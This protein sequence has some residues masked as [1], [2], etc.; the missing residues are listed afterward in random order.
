MI[1]WLLRHI[2]RIGLRWFYR[3]IEVVGAE[4]LPGDGPVLLV[5]NHNNALIDALLVVATMP[6]RVRL[7]AKATLLDHVVTRAAVRAVGIIPLRRASDEANTGQGDPG[8]E[9]NAE[10]FREIVATLVAGHV[11][12]LFPE[13]KSHS[14]PEL[15]PLR[16]GAARLVRQV[17]RAS[18]SVQVAI[19]PVGLVYEDKSVPRSRV[20]VH[21][22]RP[23]HPDRTS[24][25]DAEGVHE[26]TRLIDAAL[27][28]VT[29]NF[30]TAF[31]ASRMFEFSGLVAG[32]LDNIRPLGAPQSPLS[33]STRIAR[34]LEQLR[35]SLPLLEP[36]T[37]LLV[38]D[39][40]RRLEA[41]GRMVAGF[42]V[43]P[44]DLWMPVTTSAGVRFAARELLI[45]L[46]TGPLALWGRINHWLPLWIARRIGRARSRY[47]DEPAMNT[48][49]SGIV[50]VILFY[51][52]GVATV[53]S[54]YG[55]GFGAL[56]LVSLPLSATVDF[57]LSER[58]RHGQHRAALYLRFRRSP[59]LQRE[60][61]A[62]AAWL[63][64]ESMRLHDRLTSELTARQAI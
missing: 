25:D 62:S 46:A 61:T 23:F 53:T 36:E 38:D 5:A 18:E 43:P 33:E 41:F 63:R 8:S 10:S 45:A 30:D 37:L 56:Y 49:V 34:R 16:T 14:E 59:A 57:W 21:V 42:G 26:L 44:N 11:V 17:L 20:M 54:L 55:W 3:D 7:T 52:L 9:R 22:G 39:F 15:A 13:G 4:E 29:V 19:V 35:Q 50:L 60:A 64:A 24:D 27:R 58:L 31:Q 12:L 40:A 32:V 51:C 6:R 1:Y 28:D 2:A 47:A 48:M